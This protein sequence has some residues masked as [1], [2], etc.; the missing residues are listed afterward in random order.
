MLEVC[1]SVSYEIKCYRNNSFS[2]SSPFL[3]PFQACPHPDSFASF[4][5]TLFYRYAQEWVLHHMP[6][7]LGF[8]RICVNSFHLLKPILGSFLKDALGCV[9]FSGCFT[10]LVVY[11]ASQEEY[12]EC[13]RLSGSYCS[14]GCRLVW[15]PWRQVPKKGRKQG[16]SFCVD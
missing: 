11:G 8:G 12:G 2:P 6:S 14:K 15:F 4:I 9:C 16:L 5:C 13:P 10:P 3:P 1:P 7:S